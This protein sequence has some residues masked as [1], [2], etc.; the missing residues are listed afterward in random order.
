MEICS[1]KGSSSCYSVSSSNQLR[2][3]CR[4]RSRCCGC[5]GTYEVVGT[6]I[7]EEGL[8]ITQIDFDITEVFGQVDPGLVPNAFINFHVD[9]NTLFTG[10]DALTLEELENT[11]DLDTPFFLVQ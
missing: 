9:G 6:A 7:S 5:G 11:L 2:W 8:D 3:W 4:F 1:A 10:N